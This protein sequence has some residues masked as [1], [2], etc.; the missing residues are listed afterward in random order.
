MTIL[1]LKNITRCLP[2]VKLLVLVGQ[3]DPLL[4]FPL[5]WPARHFSLF[6]PRRASLIRCESS[7]IVERVHKVWH[8]HPGES[9][10]SCRWRGRKRSHR[11]RPKGGLT[12]SDLYF[13]WQIFKQKSLGHSPV[14][15]VPA[16]CVY[17]LHGSSV[18][19]DSPP[20]KIMSFLLKTSF[21]VDTFDIREKK[22][23]WSY[24]LKVREF[25]LGDEAV[26]AATQGDM[27]SFENV[28]WWC[29]IYFSNN[30]TPWKLWWDIMSHV[31]RKF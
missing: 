30:W 14:A 9:F 4:T 15:S 20:G 11:C 18:R 24:S 10:S 19:P 17:V 29:L 25:G 13:V 23:F 12:A 28:F 31:L 22:H 8:I 7:A 16:S 27:V 2:V 1:S 21:L 6:C 26:A 3:G 5:P